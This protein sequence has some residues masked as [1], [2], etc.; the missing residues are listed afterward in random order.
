VSISALIQGCAPGALLA[1]ALPRAA[2]LAG[3]AARSGGA[4][5]RRL[6]THLV[7]GAPFDAPVATSG[8]FDGFVFVSA[9][10]AWQ[11]PNKANP[12]YPGYALSVPAVDE[13]LA[14]GTG[15]PNGSVVIT[16][17]CDP[18]FMTNFDLGYAANQSDFAWALNCADENVG[19]FGASEPTLRRSFF[20]AIATDGDASL[21]AR[22]Q[23]LY[24][25]AL[26]HVPAAPSWTKE[27]AITDYDY[28][29]PLPPSP[30][31]FDADMDALAAAIPLERRNTVAVCVH[32]WYGLIGQYTLSTMN[33][34]QLLDSWVVF[35]DG[36]NYVNPV[37]KQP[38][39]PIPMTKSLIHARI[40]KARSLGFRTL[41]YFSDG[42]N[43]CEGVPFWREQSELTTYA[44]TAPWKGPDSTGRLFVRNPLHP[45][46]ITQVTNYVA[47]LLDEYGS[48]IDGL[49]WD[50]TFEMAHNQVGVAGSAPGYAS[51]GML[52]LIESVARQ[53]H[54]SPACKECVLLVAG[55]MFA[56]SIPSAL[57]TDGT[58]EDVGLNT[59]AA[60]YGT[61]PNYRNALW[62][63]G[64]DDV[65]ARG[66]EA[67][68]A[69]FNIPVGVS[70]GWGDFRGFANLTSD[71][72]AYF[73]GLSLNHSAQSGPRFPPS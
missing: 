63:C 1:I 48:S 69:R 5:T 16:V 36:A 2:T 6:A 24:A 10:E 61:L 45:S 50:E 29:S 34:T 56:A 26:A 12:A 15:G 22:M 55:C 27:I 4:M 25:T 3:E 37:T 13:F 39:G 51:L 60:P 46:T 43:S 44:G 38:M 71:V 70:N 53:L 31:G 42:I 20:T 18:Y 47:G 33:S 68:M 40:D 67:V 30:N 54:A 72:Q 58:Y 52:R 11:A 19:C 62:E 7:S 65:S 23:R 9:G 21:D 57:V 66:N 35:P 49:V 17:T 41:L 32:G 8:D 59:A 64:W 28:F 14:S 73:V